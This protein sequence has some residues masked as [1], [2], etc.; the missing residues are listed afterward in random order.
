MTVIMHGENLKLNTAK[1]RCSSL[2][3]SLK[4]AS[5]Y[6]DFNSGLPTINQECQPIPREIMKYHSLPVTQLQ[7]TL[8]GYVKR[9]ISINPQDMDK[10][11]ENPN[12][13]PE[14]P[15]KIR[16]NPNKILENPNK[17]LENPNKILENPKSF[18]IK[19]INGHK[20]SSINLVYF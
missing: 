14:N 4:N 16:E 19:V 13:I 17:I 12:K 7:L 20:A 1:F 9:K 2:N 15:N 18:V 5:L 3:I 10:I 8:L 11:R 6:Q